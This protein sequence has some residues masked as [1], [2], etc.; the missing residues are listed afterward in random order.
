MMS[1]KFVTKKFEDHS[2]E[3]GEAA[4]QKV[5]EFDGI[6]VDFYGINSARSASLLCPPF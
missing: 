4:C 5:K 3:E 2:L 6:F 1:L